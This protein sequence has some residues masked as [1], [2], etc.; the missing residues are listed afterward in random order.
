[1]AKKSS[2]RTVTTPFRRVVRLV[3]FLAQ[4][5]T[6]T[7]I[8]LALTLILALGTVLVWY[9]ELGDPAQSKFGIDDAFVFMLQNVSG[10]GIGATPP[11]TPT[12]RGIGV[13]FVILAAGMRAIFVAAVVS[14]FVNRLILQGKGLRRV[15]L[16]NHVIICGWN[17]RVKQIV[18][19]LQRDSTRPKIPIV[20][21]ASINENPLVEFGV[22]FI[23]GDPS[24]TDD[25]QRAGVDVAL[26]AMVITDESDGQPHTD[27]TYDARS[28]LTVLAIKSVNPKLHVIAEVRDPSNRRHFMNARADEVV[29]SAE[30]SEG[31]VARA[32]T[33]QGIAWVYEDLLRL[34]STPEMYVIDAP[35]D[36][37]GK[38]FQAALVRL[39]TRDNVVLL[40][41]IENSKVTMCPPNDC[42]IGA[43]AQLVVLSNMR[44]T[45][46]SD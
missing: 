43:D 17:A 26:S 40:G 1:M 31:V 23:K 30:V 38:A 41:L 12:A 8:F 18:K 5:N 6:Y 35:K 25:L 32:A 46:I 16:E 10:V 36:L 24:L 39:N 11:L 19:T 15:D 13:T 14:S 44:P 33:N 4:P 45:E 21:L 27:S 20:L 42:L 28:V 7:I 3:R 22:K 29:V 34:D 37:V 2:Q 9:F